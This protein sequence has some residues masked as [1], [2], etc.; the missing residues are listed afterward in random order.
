MLVV[1]GLGLDARSWAPV[2]ARLGWPVTVRTL[3]GY[4]EPVPRGTDLAPAVLARRVAD[5][6]AG[7]GAG[8]PVVLAAHSS[9]CQVAAHAARLAPERVAALVLVGPTTDP[10]AAGW[11]ALA[12]R[13]LATAAREDPRQ[14]PALARQYRRTGLGSMTRTMDAARRDDVRR[15]LAG[16][17]CPVLVVRGPHDR[18]CPA[19]WAAKLGRP[20]TLPRGAHMVVTTHGA[21][22]AAA[23]TAFLTGEGLA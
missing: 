20:V 10:R 5:D 18:I 15:A 2:E 12:R 16:L 9:G 11:P 21:D 1:P 17:T 19:D 14:V 23:V 13:W 4:G 22:V 8:P 3:P 6:L 7:L